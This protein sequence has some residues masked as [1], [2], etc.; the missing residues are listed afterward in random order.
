MWMFRTRGCREEIY[1]NTTVA[2]AIADRLVYNSEVLI[3][4]GPSYRKRMKDQAESIRIRAPL[5]PPSSATPAI[6]PRKHNA[7]LCPLQTVIDY[8][9]GD[10]IMV[11]PTWTNI[12]FPHDADIHPDTGLDLGIDRLRFIIPGNVFEIPSVAVPTGI[13]DGLPPVCRSMLNAV[14]LV[15]RARY[16]LIYPPVMVMW[17]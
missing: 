7:Q 13:I 17:S 4:E 14:S 9:T 10:P 15:V 3:M 12:Q 11:G 2:T 1:G 16:I 6:A 8:Q 5:H